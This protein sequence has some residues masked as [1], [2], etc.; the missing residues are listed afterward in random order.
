MVQEFVL[1]VT[2]VLKQIQQDLVAKLANLVSS[3]HQMAHVNYAHLVMYLTHKAHVNV[4]NVHLVLNQ[5]I[6]A[7]H[8]TF[9]LLVNSLLMVLNA[10]HVLILILQLIKAHLHVNLAQLVMVILT[11]KLVSL[12]IQ[13]VLHVSV[14]NQVV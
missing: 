8:V 6:I 14:V 11:L 12:L 10:K 2:V 4:I 7:K 1:H 9:V 3:H 5:T 13:D